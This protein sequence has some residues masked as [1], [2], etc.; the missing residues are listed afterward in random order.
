MSMS[1]EDRRVVTTTCPPARRGSRAWTRAALYA[2]ALLQIG[3]PA[4]LAGQEQSNPAAV[5][6]LSRALDVEAE[7]T[8]QAVVAISLRLALE[9]RGLRV[10]LQDVPMSDQA[11]S[12]DPLALFASGAGK[13]ADYLLLSQYASAGQDLEVRLAWHGRGSGSPAAQL[14]RRGRKDLAL[15]HMILNAVEELLRTANPS[16]VSSIPR[17]AEQPATAQPVA[18]EPVTAQSASQQP[19]VHARRKRFDIGL[20]VA[21]FVATGQASEYFKL[22]IVPVLNAVFLFRGEAGRLGLGVYTGANLFSAAGSMETESVALVPTG[23]LLRYEI[24]REG[25]PLIVFGVSAGPAI[26]SMKKQTEAALTGLTFY[27]RATLG[28]RLPIGRVFGI[29]AEAGYD[30]YWEQP[31][32]ITGFCPALYATIRL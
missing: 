25:T 24:G 15:D 11:L 3:L 8:F 20:G 17:P 9:R 21:P 4:A 7:R 26:L 28:I 16:L 14:T 29:G 31:Y 32:P 23:L 22:G 27:G 19:T 13:E 6:V 18:G 1:R 2:F 12:A 5:L 10:V 30:F